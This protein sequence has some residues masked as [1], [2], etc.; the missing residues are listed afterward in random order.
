LHQNKHSQIFI[1]YVRKDIWLAVV[2]FILLSAANAQTWKLKAPEHMLSAVKTSTGHEKADALNLLAKQTILFSI[3][4][5]VPIVDE[6]LHLA[7]SLHYD[8]GE[9][10]AIENNALLFFRK[11][12]F[13][14][15]IK[16]MNHAAQIYKRNNYHEA[17]INC[18]I[19]EAG[20]F[21]FVD[22]KGEIT[23]T[24]IQALNAAKEI[25]RLDLE[26][27]TE[28]YFGQY[29]LKT[30]DRI[31]AWTYLSQAMAS[32]KK[33]KNNTAIGNAIYGMALYH[34]S[35]KQY[36]KAIHYLRMAF[37]K[38]S[39]ANE[40]PDKMTVFSSMGD[41]FAACN[42]NDSAFLYYHKALHL[43]ILF[44]DAGRMASTYTR[45]AHVL[46]QEQNLDSALYYQK[47]ALNL[48][49]KQGNR[50][51]TGSSLTNIGIIYAQ[52]RDFNRA[53]SYYKQ[54]L[55]LAK[56]TGYQKY[57]QFNYQCLYKLYLAQNNY[58]KAIEYNLLLSSINDSI[59]SNETRQKFTRIQARYE[60][61]QKQKAIGFLTK[62]NDI[63]KL[64]I[65]QT[66][67]MIY[68]LGALLI[69]IIVIGVLLDMHAK[70]NTRHLQMIS[71]QKLLRSQMNPH[72]IFNAL[73]SIQGFIYNNESE[74]AARYLT[75]FARLIRLVLSNSRE[76]FITLQREIDMLENY[77]ALQKM[78]FKNK[79]DYT[80][81]VDPGLDTEFIN[82]P[83]MLAQ[84]F[85]ENAIEQGIFGMTKSGY[86][87]VSILAS[88][89][90]ILIQ[91][92]D[93]GNMRE[94]N[95][96]QQVKTVDS[97]KPDAL[98]ITKERIR[99]L[100]HKHALKIIF[101]T[102]E[103]KDENNQITGTIAMLLI[104]ENR[105]APAPLVR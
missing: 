11:G 93:N 63:Q 6:A 64:K 92:E 72:F 58:Q 73:V 20:Y 84:P 56:K 28:G 25:G 103:L 34:G 81:I 60:S 29:L 50:T 53:L 17:F 43:G 76:E 94:I 90:N 46:Q 31:N 101:S 14:K 1:T 26:S 30:G 102:N 99:Q 71:E 5:A 74:T 39:S 22:D 33:S 96:A 36:Q 86:I 47:I 104:P 98:R 7:I 51:L 41:F 15:A 91:V 78:R 21:E 61:E 75:R 105:M 55:A 77:L 8:K 89:H 97:A 82:I 69:L 10:D 27:K 18:L 12:D 37:H 83:P 3:S 59:L 66:R 54:G 23:A 67:F 42:E 38:V 49:H 2:F 35:D 16:L 44:N 32:S 100:N 87:E 88:N 70:L 65:N 40:N 13:H 62:E 4:A 45:I 85:L 80:F 9:A 19:L 24:Y 68:I 95:L 57:I 79:F 52:K 48:R